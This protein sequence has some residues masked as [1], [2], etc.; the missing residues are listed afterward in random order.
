M[1]SIRRAT[2][3]APPPDP[4]GERRRPAWRER[5]QLLGAAFEFETDSP[6]LLRIVRAAYADLP[7]HRLGAAPPTLRVRLLLG[8]GNRSARAARNEPPAVRALSGAGLLGGAMDGSSFVAVNARERAALVVVGGAMQRYPYHARYELLEFAVYVLAARAQ[9]LVPLHAACLAHA[10]AGVLLM[11]ASGAGKST[12]V[13]HG[14]L[15]GLEFLAEDSVLIEPRTL[16][17]TGVARFVHLR[18]DSLALLARRERAAL[19]RGAAT[20]RRRSGVEKLEIDVRRREYRLAA[21][22]VI[23]ALVFLSRR[24]A[25][26]GGLLI[27]M[28]PAVARRRL[29]ATQRYAARQPGWQAFQARLSGV[30]VYELRRGDHPA[31][32]VEALREIL[33]R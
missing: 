15:G 23:R 27:P 31:A 32:G 19:T 28:S 4:F 2:L 20:I 21:A 6:R 25:Y 29:A 12:L 14:L 9:S 11:G 8:S 22:P 13:L 33:A 1:A 30:P 17:A 18:R 16:R 24:R 5:L 7:P 10:G 26:G 3:A